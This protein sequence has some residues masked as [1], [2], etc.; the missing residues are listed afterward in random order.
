MRV[1]TIE[2][3]NV[4]AGGCGEPKV[5]PP[6]KDKGCGS[7]KASSAK[8]SAKGSSAKK[9]AKASSG[10]GCAPKPPKCEVFF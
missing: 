4:V 10:K 9:S 2:E 8:K 7:G 5:K 1:L 3:M 6:K